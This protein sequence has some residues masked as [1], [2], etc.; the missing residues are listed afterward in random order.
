MKKNSKGYWVY[1][2]QC[3]CGGAGTKN[4]KRK[5][6]WNPHMDWCEAYEEYGAWKT[7]QERDEDTRIT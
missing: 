7:A 5:L 6:R 1:E 4:E 3:M 2:N